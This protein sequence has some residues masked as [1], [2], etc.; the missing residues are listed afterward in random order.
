MEDTFKVELNPERRR[1][2]LARLTWLTVTPNPSTGASTTSAG[3]SS[4]TISG[5]VAKDAL[6]FVLEAIA[7]S[8]DAFPP[9]KSAANGLLFF[10]T[11]ADVSLCQFIHIRA[12]D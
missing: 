8:S 1:T 7:Q 11:C 4:R 3:A 12:A 10:A 6:L 5:T 9:L 2:E